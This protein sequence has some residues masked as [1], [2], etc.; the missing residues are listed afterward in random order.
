MS[1]LIPDLRSETNNVIRKGVAFWLENFFLG[2]GAPKYYDKEAYPIDIHSAAVAIAAMCELK[3][4]DKRML[5]MAMK[6]AKWTIENM[7]ESQGYFYYRIRK[8]RVVKTPF[9][10]WGQAWMAYALARLIVSKD[11]N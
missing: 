10:R 5:P 11:G 6:T 2:D 3:T 7:L 9:M 8:N 4:I 1:N